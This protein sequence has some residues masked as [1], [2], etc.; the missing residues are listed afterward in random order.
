MS[1]VML[2][3]IR[4]ENDQETFAN[5]SNTVISHQLQ[6]KYNL[7]FKVKLVV[8]ALTSLGYYNKIPQTVWLARTRE[9]YF[10]TVLDA[11]ES[12]IKVWAN[13]VPP[14]SSIPGLQMAVFLQCQYIVG[15]TQSLSS[16]SYKATNS[17]MRAP[18]S[19]SWPHLTLIFPQRLHLQTP[20]HWDYLR[21]YNSV[22][23]SGI[24]QSTIL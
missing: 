4:N 14:E 19:S 6:T 15:R 7:D 22:H 12:K 23:C 9:I 11:G 5:S 8:C 18:S 10:L 1:F 17:I 2:V 24:V 16:S 21:G 3:K 20:S 13:L